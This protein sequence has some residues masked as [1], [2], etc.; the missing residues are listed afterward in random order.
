MAAPRDARP[1]PLRLN[2]RRFEAFIRG[3]P[4]RGTLALH[5]KL[6]G[7]ALAH[8]RWRRARQGVTL[9][10]SSGPRDLGTLRA[11]LAEIAPLLAR[12]FPRAPVEVALA[13]GRRALRAR[14]G[15]RGAPRSRGAGAGAG[16]RAAAL[17]IARVLA[18]IPG[19]YARARGLPRIAEART[20]ALA[21][22]DAAGREC[23]LRPD[24][25]RRWHALAAAARRD[26]VAI[27]LVSGF[28]SAAYQARIL[29]R[30]HARGEPMVRILAVNAAPGHSEHHGGFALDL[31]APGLPPVEASFEDTPA[32]RWLAARAARLRLRMSYPRDN[33][34]GILHEPW[35]WRFLP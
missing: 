12:A 28:R 8:G 10:L 11:A 20:L 34:H 30:K 3:G 33:P 27:E 21:G 2:A 15:R 17:A 23:W 14:L 6:D 13:A 25:A 22:I 26:G 7:A 19:D 31:G 5:R 1:W 29:E 24:I 35:H 4:R 9:E 18:M 32:Y 16:A